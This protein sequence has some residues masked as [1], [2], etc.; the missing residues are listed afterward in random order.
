MDKI[1]LGLS[2]STRMLGMAVFKENT[3]IDYF[4]KLNKAKWSVEKREY[5][6]ASLASCLEHYAIA[7]VVILMPENHC[8]TEEFN[9]LLGAIQSFFQEYNVPTILYDVRD[10]YHEFG[11]PVRRTRN[12]LMKHLVIFYPELDKYY[13]KELTNK[14]KYYIKLFEAVAAGGHH[15]LKQNQK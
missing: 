14:N 7:D 4:L 13:Q 6:L 5:I 2:F 3:L 15:W 9:K 11:S 12:S 1:T 8:L 10:I